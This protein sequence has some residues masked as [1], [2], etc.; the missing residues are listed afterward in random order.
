M[1]VIW[2]TVFFIELIHGDCHKDQSKEIRIKAIG[3]YVLQ[4]SQEAGLG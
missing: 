1:W 2:S 3:Q 4:W